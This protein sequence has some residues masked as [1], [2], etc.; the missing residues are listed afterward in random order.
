MLISSMNLPW[1]KPKIS[2]K[3]QADC[4]LIISKLLKNGFSLSQAI[5]CLQYVHGSAPIY[6][7]IYQD[8]SSGYTLSASLR[9]LELPSVVQNQLFIAQVSGDLQVTIER[10]GILLMEKSKQLNKLVELLTYPMFVFSFLILMMFGMKLYI[11]PELQAGSNGSLDMLLGSGLLLLIG[12]LMF[13]IGFYIWLKHHDEYRRA[14]ILIHLPIVGTSYLCFYQFTILQ[15]WSMQFSSGLDLQKICLNDQNF[16]DGSIQN[17]IAKRILYCLKN[18][19]QF[20]RM[21]EKEALL[22]NELNVLLFLGGATKEVAQDLK[23]LS[24]LKFEE[25]QKSIKNLLKI[26]Q[27]ILFFI[28]AIFILVAYLMIL[29]PVY[30]MMKGMS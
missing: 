9:C 25:T 2:V 18:G 20:Q 16:V 1:V 14:Q 28:I 22:P 27:P 5:R 29:L 15:G 17:V 6:H 26:I 7:Q 24:E 19:N 10:C 13:G 30:G 11:L 12:T 8:L 3:Q 21:I 23:V 4:L